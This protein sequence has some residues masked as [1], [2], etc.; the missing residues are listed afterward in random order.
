M[1][2]K[3]NDAQF[4]MVDIIKTYAKTW[5]TL[6]AYDENQ[7]SL[8]D[9]AGDVPLVDLD[10]REVL[11]FITFLKEELKKKGEATPFFGL[12]KNYGL[13]SILGNISQTFNKIAV[14]P[15]NTE[16]AAHLLYFIIKDH[17][18]SDGN[19][20]I[21]CFI[22]LMFLHKAAISLDKIHNNGLIALAL[23]IAESDHKQ[24]DMM[25]KLITRLIE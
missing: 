17:P 12:E 4:P 19:K 24:K 1:N 22:F 7:L 16:R 25:I 9:D 18:F 10:Y 14:Y 23:F 2:N 13:K 8:F 15:S 20:R 5:T 3:K 21:G 6:L 11:E